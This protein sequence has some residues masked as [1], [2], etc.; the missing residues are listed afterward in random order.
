MCKCFGRSPCFF[1]MMYKNCIS[2]NISL[3]FNCIRNF[4]N[5]WLTIL[6]QFKILKLDKIYFIVQ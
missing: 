2:I 4:S 1:D 6:R 3:I 5:L